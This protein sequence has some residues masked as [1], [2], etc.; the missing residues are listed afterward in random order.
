MA[1]TAMMPICAAKKAKGS[2]SVP[3]FVFRAVLQAV[4]DRQRHQ[5]DDD[6][7]REEVGDRLR[8]RVE[9]REEIRDEAGR[10]RLEIL[11]ER[12]DRA[13]LEDQV[14]QAAKTSMPAS[15]TMKAGIFW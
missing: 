9:K 4:V 2:F 8:H 14:G 11:R 1:T 6:D 12:A 5:R 13:V 15:V 10:Q 3:C 7:Q